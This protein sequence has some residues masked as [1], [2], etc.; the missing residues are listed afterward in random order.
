MPRSSLICIRGED[1]RVRELPTRDGHP[2]C[3]AV[4]SG[5]ERCEMMA[6]VRRRSPNVVQRWEV[7]PDC[8]GAVGI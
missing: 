3:D 5:V 1:R 7:I 8:F 2:E 6:L 4:W